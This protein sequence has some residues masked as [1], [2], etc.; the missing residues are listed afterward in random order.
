MSARDLPVLEVAPIDLDKVPRGERPLVREMLSRIREGVEARVLAGK[1]WL[2]LSQ[3]TQITIYDKTPAGFRGFWDRLGQIGRG[4]MHPLLFDMGG[5]AAAYLTKLPVSD[6]ASY[7]N[8]G[9]PLL[10]GGELKMVDATALSSA[11]VT[12]VFS[13]NGRGVKVRS[14]AAQRRWLSER[15]KREKAKAVKVARRKRNF[16]IERRGK[17][18]VEGDRVRVSPALNRGG[19][20]LDDVNA[21]ARDM[22][23]L[24][25]V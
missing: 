6:Q 24:Y 9:V 16:K 5:R 13:A 2:K 17:W 25:D 15:E 21:I 19:L 20:T 7:L 10:E 4:E 3:E 11:Q 14:L 8:E 22:R 1:A 12:Q 18:T 23:R